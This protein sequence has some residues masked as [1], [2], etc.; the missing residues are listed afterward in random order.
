MAAPNLAAPLRITGKCAFT[1]LGATTEATILT[2]GTASS[3]CLRVTSLILAN[4]DGTAAVD[5]TV[6]LYNAASGGTAFRVVSTLNVPAD[7]SVV[8]LG[9]DNAVYLEEDR[10]ITIQAS[11]A[12]DLEAI[13]SYEEVT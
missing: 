1:A 8:V 12:N 7:S 10:R 9:R 11:A 2:N 4:V 6:R 3:A 5:A 13:L